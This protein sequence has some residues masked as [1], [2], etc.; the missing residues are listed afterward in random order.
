VDQE[1]YGDAVIISGSKREVL[2]YM[3]RPEFLRQSPIP[4]S[5]D[6][7]T[8]FG[9]HDKVTHEKEAR[10]LVRHLREVKIPAFVDMLMAH[11]DLVRSRFPTLSSQSIQTL[12]LRR[13]C[14]LF[15]FH[16]CYTHME[17]IFVISVI[18]IHYLLRII[19]TTIVT[20]DCV[21]ILLDSKCSQES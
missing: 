15:T 8:K 5:S 3:L 1:I 21:R 19:H 6:V 17:L 7:F 10:D 20:K 11:P 16:P 12:F 13:L 9:E 14:L 2:Y 18:F 4:I